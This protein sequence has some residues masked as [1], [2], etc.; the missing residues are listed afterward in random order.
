M[1]KKSA[2]FLMVLVT[3]IW[4]ANGLLIKLVDWSPMAISGLRS[5]FA[6]AAL[7]PFMGKPHQW[8]S[9]STLA[10]GAGFAGAMVTFVIATKL[11][12]AAN[13][14]FLQ[15]TAPVYVALL[16]WWI[17]KERIS[18]LDWIITASILG[19]MLLFFGDNLTMAGFWGNISAILSAVCWAVFVLFYRKEKDDAPLKI[20]ITG[21]V[22][23]ILT[24][25]PFVIHAGWWPTAGGIWVIPMGALGAGL[26]FVLYTWVIKRLEAIEAVI[27]Q[28]IEPIFNPVWVFLVVGEKPGP[29]ALLGGGIVLSSIVLHAIFRPKYGIQRPEVSKLRL[30]QRLP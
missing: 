28:T 25:L 30:E 3:L 24:G 14:I 20:P 26:S 12:T 1:S 13:A 27:T 9:L 17:L 19:G 7:A 18:A 2:L 6:V 16:S 5:L 11:T 10:G 29:W 23:C 22:L 8:L 15:L 4:S 21:H